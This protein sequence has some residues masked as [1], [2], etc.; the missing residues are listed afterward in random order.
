MKTHAC[1]LIIGPP[2]VVREAS[3]RF[4]EHD[5]LV[6]YATWPDPDRP[7]QFIRGH[8]SNPEVV[9]HSMYHDLSILCLQYDDE[10]LVTG[11]SDSTCIVHDMKSRDK[12]ECN[13]EPFKPIRKLQFHTAAV[14]DLSFD[15]RFIV[16]CSKDSNICV[17]DRETGAL[18]QTLRGHKGPV[19]A[20]QLRGNTIVS[21][22]G[23]F[24]VKLWDITKFSIIQD[25]T[26][27][28][29]GLACSQFS[30]DSKYIASA[31]ND[32]SIRIWNANTYEC[33]HHVEKAHSGLVR[34]LHID[35]ISGRLISGSYDS[36]IKV[37][38]MANGREIII[39]PEW[40]A[41]WVLGAKSNYRHIVSTGQEPKIMIQDFGRDVKGIDRLRS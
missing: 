30:E 25:L 5:H 34:S 24:L 12:P 1:T 39:F 7:G 41:S 11:S 40:H 28:T 4:D 21:C 6:H 36:S 19:N 3:L 27:H 29:K 20:V 8:E 18:L 9:S 2:E 37:Y 33:I 16:T 31:G 23:D 13:F 22:S 10:I 38:D 26:G 17:W 32:K 35:S 15:K 14:L